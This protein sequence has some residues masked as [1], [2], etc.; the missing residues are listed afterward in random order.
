MQSSGAQQKQSDVQSQWQHDA[1]ISYSRKNEAFADCLERALAGYAP[2]KGLVAPQRRLKIFRDKQDFTGTEYHRSLEKHLTDSA[3]L[4]LICS[5]EATQ[6]QY[7]NDEIRQFAR[8][9]GPAGIIPVLCSGIPNNEAKP[10]QESQRAF[11]SALCDLMAMPLAADFRGFVPKKN[12]INSRIYRDAWYTTLA[13]IYDLPRA[14]IEE[15]DKKRRQRTRRITVSV[16]AAILCLIAVAAIIAW[17]SR[18]QAQ[19]EARDAAQ[20]QY[21]GNIVRA[22]QAYAV[23]DLPGMRNLL[24]AVMPA[25][26]DPADDFRGFE[27]YY[28]WRL[29]QSTAS[30]IIANDCDAKALAFSPDGKLFAMGGEDGTVKLWSTDSRKELGRMPA[31]GGAVKGLAFSPDGKILATAAANSPVKLWD[32]NSRTLAGEIKELGNSVEGVAFSPTAPVLAGVGY[33]NFDKMVRVWDMQSQRVVATFKGD[34]TASASNRFV[35]FSPD[36][37]T[38]ALSSGFG[39]ELRRLQSGEKIAAFDGPGIYV[40]T[41]AFSPNG[42]TLIAAADNGK[43]LFFDLKTR[44]KS[45]TLDAH[46]DYVSSLA[47][48]PDGRSFVTASADKTIKLWDAA[49]HELRTAWKGHTAM[50]EAISISTDGRTLVSVAQDKTVRLWDVSARTDYE[51]KGDLDILMQSIAPSPRDNRLALASA[52]TVVVWD[53]SARKE[54][55]R[56]PNHSESIASVAF[57]PDQKT[58]AIGSGKT[59]E[60]WDTI[61]GNVEALSAHTDQVYG[62]AFSPDGKWLASASEDHTVRIWNMSARR[63]APLSLT[64][65]AKAVTAVAFSPDSKTLA[66]GSND[67]TV[68]LWDVGSWHEIAS[69]PAFAALPSTDDVTQQPLVTAMSFSPNA[70]LLAA[71]SADGTAIL[72]RVTSRTLQKIG[73]LAGHTAGINSLAFSP[74]GRTIATASSDTT[75]KLWRASLLRELITINEPKS[76]KEVPHF[77]EGSENQVAAVA[78][79]SDGKFLVTGMNDGTVR[80]R[81]AATSSEVVTDAQK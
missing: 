60:L 27:W 78:F 65:Y 54:L 61:S 20:L 38:L 52:S 23:T 5:P 79:S 12:K 58:I 41:I 81:R 72:W 9:K 66:T 55:A 16:T 48:S 50:V 68:K 26:T 37:A 33:E 34:G 67:G 25:S 44:H 49:S 64:G 75:V 31:P 47:F 32:M 22:Q 77:I 51:E 8:L 10:G 2:P 13:N 43:L 57:S 35:A 71:A 14:E 18:L 17:R 80:F 29:N 45:G 74:D 53:P 15:R 59:V 69:S 42:K 46:Q 56:L 7:V 76:G 6:S 28:L 39:V 70:E 3:K 1:F 36:G 62:L 4:I 19:K 21:I 11:P 63:A 73:P 24:Q 40:T 30:T